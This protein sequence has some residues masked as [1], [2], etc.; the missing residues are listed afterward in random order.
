MT[1]LRLLYH[2]MLA[3]F[4][5]RTRR[6]SFLVL[7]IVNFYL[8]Y[9]VFV[10]NFTPRVGDYRGEVNCAWTGSTI[11]FTS[12]FML[13]IFG[14]YLVKNA[15]ARDY[16]TGVG[17]ILAT[18]P[19]RTMWYLVGKSLSN[20]AVLAAMVAAVAASAVAMQ[21]LGNSTGDF[22][23]WALLSPFLFLALPPL[24]FV[25]SL[26]TLFESIRWLRGGLG[27]VVF[28][29]FIMTTLPFSTELN[30]PVLDLSGMRLLMDSLYAAALAQYPGAKLNFVLNPE[31]IANLKSFHWTGIDWSMAIIL[32]RLFWIAAAGAVTLLAAVFFNRFD[33]SA[34]K[35]AK[36][37]RPAPA[38]NGGN[39]KTAVTPA[40]IRMAQLEPIRVRF[41]FISMI[42]AELR[43]SLKG[44][45]KIWYLVAAGLLVAQLLAPLT[46]VRQYLMPAAWI[47]PILLW[48]SMGTRERRFN[49]GQVV[50]SSPYPLA[51]QLPAIW[52]SGVIVAL[53]TGG[54]AIL[55]T[56]AA[57]NSVALAAL[58]VG[59]LFV[60][61]MAL[62]LGAVSGTSRLF[63][64]I[65]L[66]VWYIGP[67]NGMPALDYMGTTD[68]AVVQGMPTVYLL[69]TILFVLVAILARRFRGALTG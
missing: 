10:G 22:D 30:V 16:Q 27:N 31:Y 46:M 29:F 23:L 11:A 20:F 18:S 4:R 45:P 14:F 62:A 42:A 21:L 12:L 56:L 13:L 7:L 37:S 33:P 43:L 49:T 25:A 63:E 61:T 34:E 58:L 3:D 65:Y 8:G 41:S 50:F 15:I 51:R 2:L 48:S 57:G 28:F 9:Q 32:P 53:L 26:A 55:R 59:A 68:T 17:Q 64:T 5:E 40:T 38:S 66:V 35:Q 52:A 36:E 44:F 19:M 24:A 54:G 60:P 69:I 39:G 6:Y 1:H 47:W 67:M